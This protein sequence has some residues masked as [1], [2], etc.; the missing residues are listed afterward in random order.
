MLLT[1]I[2]GHRLYG[3]SFFDNLQASQFS[4]SLLEHNVLSRF[5]L[6]SHQLLRQPSTSSEP[7]LGKHGQGE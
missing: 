6:L 3:G 1:V 7:E 4:S 2:A 5:L